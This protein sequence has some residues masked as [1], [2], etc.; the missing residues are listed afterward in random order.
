MSE[1]LLIMLRAEERAVIVRR[2]SLAELL[3]EVAPS[4][5]RSSAEQLAIR[6][7][8]AALCRELLLELRR[9]VFRQFRRFTRRRRRVGYLEWRRTMLS[10]VETTCALNRMP[11][12]AEEEEEDE[13]CPDSP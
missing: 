9:A 2:F 5:V 3:E 4:F 7:A 10:I 1:N 12:L 11:W 6:R 8:R 13:D